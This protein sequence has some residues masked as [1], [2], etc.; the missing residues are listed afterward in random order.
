MTSPAETCPTAVSRR[1]LLTGG[2]AG[3]FLLAFHLPCARGQRAGAAARRDRR[4]VRAQRLHP[5]RSGRQ[6]HAGHA[7][8][9]DGAGHLHLGRDDPR[10]RARRRFLAGRRSS[11]RRRTTS[12]TPIPLFGI[13]VDRRLQFGPRV[14]EAAAQRR[15]QRARHAGAGRRAAVAGRARELHRGERRGDPRRQRPQA[16]LWRAGRGRGQQTPPKDVAAQ[17][18]E[19]FQA[20]RQAAEAPRHAGQG[21]RQGRLRHRRDAARHEVRDARG[22]SRCS[23]ARSARSTTAPPRRFPACGRS[24]CSTIWSRS[25]AITCGPPR[26]ASTRS[27]STWDEGPNASAQFE[28]HLAGSARR[29]REGR[30]G[31]EIRRRYRQGAWRPATKFEAAYELPF[32]AHAHDGAAELHRSSASPT[33]ARSGPARRSWR[34]CSRRRR[35]PP[36]CRSRR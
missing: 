25:S 3:G 33:P 22:M 28:G 29:Q 16:R 7:A 18:P 9:R 12:S 11:T 2:L 19:G 15:R 5:H 1:A 8:G 32:L 10:R 13:Q 27:T 6:D 20:D 26:R 30:R 17:G 21:Q 34:G 4:Q 24:S 31:R 36:A 14:L 23:A 35:R